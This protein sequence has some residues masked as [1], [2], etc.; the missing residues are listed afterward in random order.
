MNADNN[1]R[2]IGDILRDLMKE[3]SQNEK[4]KLKESMENSIRNSKVKII[5]SVFLILEGMH[6]HS[7]RPEID[8]SVLGNRERYFDFL[9]DLELQDLESYHSSLIIE[10]DDILKHNG[11]CL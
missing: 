5:E 11:H 6:A 8:L 3:R 10:C 9:Y 1:T 4:N 7:A 2:P